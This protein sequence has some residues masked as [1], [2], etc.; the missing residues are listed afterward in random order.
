MNPGSAASGQSTSFA[1]CAARRVRVIVSRMSLNSRLILGLPLLFLRNVRL[2]DRD[3]RE[4]QRA[5]VVRMR[6]APY[7]ASAPTIAS[8]ATSRVAIAARCPRSSHASA[9]SPFTAAMQKLSPRTPGQVG[10]LREHGRARE[11]EPERQPRER[12]VGH[13][14]EHH[15]GRHPHHRQRAAPSAARRAPQHEQRDRRRPQPRAR[16]RTTPRHSPE[17]RASCRSRARSRSSTDWPRSRACRTRSR[18]ARLRAS[19]PAWSARRA[20]A[21]ANG[22]RQKNAGMSSGK[23]GNAIAN[24][25]VEAAERRPLAPFAESSLGE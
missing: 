15:L 3:G 13:V 2:H 22:T 24:S 12:E 19:E 20:S 14:V 25:S 6:H 9:I 16:A 23:G 4:R 21:T 17:S 10:G 8:A 1:S 18:G 7:A 5:R 11:R